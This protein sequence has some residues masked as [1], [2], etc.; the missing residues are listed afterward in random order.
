MLIQEHQKGI[1]H[2]TTSL[3]YVVKRKV[4]Q[5]IHVICLPPT[6]IS[7]SW[8][9]HRNFV[10]MM[11][12]SIY[13]FQADTGFFE[14]NKNADCL[15]NTPTCVTEQDA[16]MAIKGTQMGLLFAL[17]SPCFREN[18]S[19]TCKIVTC[20]YSL[21]NFLLKSVIVFFFLEIR[22]QNGAHLKKRLFLT[23][24]SHFLVTRE[25]HKI[26]FCTYPTYIH[27]HILLTLL[28][29]FAIPIAKIVNLSWF[30]FGMTPGVDSLQ[31]HF[32]AINK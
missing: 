32:G 13:T 2:S 3:Q 23:C 7:M 5:K 31:C 29:F 25:R 28:T 8:I 26:S 24:F 21:D 30:L 17:V 27:T 11:K 19:V 14:V 6:C 15:D 20:F 1:Y 4:D 12:S 16:D 9:N 10:F 22:F 18:V